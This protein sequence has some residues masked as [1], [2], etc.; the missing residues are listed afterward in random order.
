MKNIIAIILVLALAVVAGQMR[1]N[2]WLSK[3]TT[4]DVS[5]ETVASKEW[6]RVVKVYDGDTFKLD[7]GVK[8]RLIGIDTPESHDNPKLARD[9]KKQGKSKREL[10]RMGQQAA[11]FS[12]SLLQDQLVRLEYD[13]SPLDKYQRT[14]AYVYLQ[15]GTFVNAKIIREGYAYPLTIPPN[16]KY[17]HQFKEYFDEARLNQRGLWR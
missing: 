7:N 10:L 11:E 4:S 6:H 16:V 17:A 1:V 2:K 5:Q 9:V 12:Q 3:R 8:V 13:V 15:D 14:L